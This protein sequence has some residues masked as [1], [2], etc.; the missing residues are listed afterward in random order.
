[1]KNAQAAC[2]VTF[3]LVL[4]VACGTTERAPNAPADERASAVSATPTPPAK[5]SSTGA[6]V[7][8]TPTTASPPAASAVPSLE[9]EARPSEFRVLAE[10]TFVHDGFRTEVSDTLKGEEAGRPAASA[11]QVGQR[12]T[13]SLRNLSRS[14]GGIQSRATINFARGLNNFVVL[15]TLEGPLTL[16]LHR[17][18]ELGLAPDTGG[19]T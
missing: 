18:G 5:A 15:P 4:A 10:T 14:S 6:P 8:N 19:F 3:L 12:V 1:M 11:S 2:F 16:Y 17:T 13:V 9:A 7:L